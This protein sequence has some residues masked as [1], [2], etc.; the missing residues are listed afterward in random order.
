MYV[1]RGVMDLHLDELSVSDFVLKS[2]EEP[3]S[4]NLCE[5]PEGLQVRPMMPA[6]EATDGR[7]AGFHQFGTLFLG[8]VILD[9]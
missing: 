3:S 2:D 9:C 1:V 4:R 8:K 7:R 5:L 6:R